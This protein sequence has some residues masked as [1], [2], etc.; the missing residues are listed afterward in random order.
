LGGLLASGFACLRASARSLWGDL[1][2]TMARE[3]RLRKE[4][5]PTA[6]GQTFGA[7][8]GG[9]WVASPTSQPPPHHRR[10]TAQP[11]A[12]PQNSLPQCFA[13]LRNCSDR[14]RGPPPLH[15]TAPAP[16]PSHPLPSPCS[17]AR[18]LP[19]YF[20]M[21]FS[22]RTAP[23]VPP[24]QDA[25]RLQ[26]PLLACGAGA[27]LGPRLTA[28]LASQLGRQAA[29]AVA[30]GHHVAGAP[31]GALAWGRFVRGG[32]RVAGLLRAG[33]S[34]AARGPRARPDG[35]AARHAAQQL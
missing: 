21:N 28:A 7:G 2:Y 19:P 23:P 15:Q 34:A 32:A 8:G 35:P 3:E 22:S 6:A 26:K 10:P 25:V 13:R 5:P 33:A 14:P 27:G 31:A 20:N 18:L 9:L 29:E 1:R 4:V 17:A 16:L 11:G 12:P 24:P 30:A